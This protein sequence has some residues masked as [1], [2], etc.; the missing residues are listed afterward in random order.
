MYDIIQ[1]PT[2]T[3][4]DSQYE[5]WARLFL[6]SPDPG[7]FIISLTM[8]ELSIAINI[9]DIAV[10]EAEKAEAKRITDLDIDVGT[11]SGVVIEAL[12][13]ALQEAVKNSILEQA[14][15]TINEIHAKA[16]CN[17]CRKVVGVTY[18]FEACPHCQSMDL[19]L[20]QGQ[21]L[22]VKSLKVV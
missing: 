22:R 7:S 9:V 13:F 21:E 8:H 10:K 4:L 16:H 1:L 19:T 18:L 20:T 3:T 15:I 17:E 14:K 6:T 5:A 11:L 12:E 2:L